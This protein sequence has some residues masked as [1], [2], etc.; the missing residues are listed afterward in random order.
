LKVLAFS[1]FGKGHIKTCKVSPDAFL[2]MTF[3]LAYYRD[4]G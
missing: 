3:Q 2:Q 1:R 4:Q